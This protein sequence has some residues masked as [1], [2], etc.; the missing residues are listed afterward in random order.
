[1]FNTE[2]FKNDY[3]N[4]L[5]IDEMK[6]KYGICNTTYFTILK[7]LGIKRPIATKINKLMH[8]NINKDKQIES[9]IERVLDKPIESKIERTLD[10]PKTPNN[11]ITSF[12]NVDVLCNKEKNIKQVYHKQITESNVEVI[13]KPTIR[14]DRRNKEKNDLLD[15]L[16][17]SANNT[18]DKVN[19]KKNKII[20]NK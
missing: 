20:N 10:K 4:Y 8:M 12:G 1:M 2:D 17:D 7:K 18:I 19:K 16:L 11:N 6:L 14:I 5:S 3:Y 13:K 9:K 15:D